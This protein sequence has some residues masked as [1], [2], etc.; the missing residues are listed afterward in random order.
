VSRRNPAVPRDI[1]RA[2]AHAALYKTRISGI[3]NACCAPGQH[4]DEH[5]ARA[6]NRRQTVFCAASGENR[7]WRTACYSC[8]MHA[9]RTCRGAYGHRDGLRCVAMATPAADAACM[10]HQVRAASVGMA[11][12]L[13]T[14][15]ANAVRPVTKHCAFRGG[16][17]RLRH[18][19]ARQRCRAI[20]KHLLALNGAGQR[21][22]HRKALAMPAHV[23]LC[24]APARVV[25]IPALALQAGANA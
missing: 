23:F 4:H 24:R 7:A 25:A 22:R 8:D 6:G 14:A 5:R 10:A 11:K 21:E 20:T 1:C 17:Q 19:K 12:Q 16:A 3:G 13:A 2:R 18:A 9:A 15:E